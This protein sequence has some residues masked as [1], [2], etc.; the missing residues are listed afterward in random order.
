MVALL[1]CIMITS[2]KWCTGSNIFKNTAR[3]R[4]REKTWREN[5]KK[6]LSTYLIFL[7]KHNRRFLQARTTFKADVNKIFNTS[8]Q[9][10]LE[11]WKA[12]FCWRFSLFSFVSFVGNFVRLINRTLRSS[13]KCFD[14]TLSFGPLAN[15]EAPTARSLPHVARVWRS[16][17]PWTWGAKKTTPVM[18][19][20]SLVV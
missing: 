20:S 9:E 5:C 7:W 11:I 13:W 1:T 6:T 8:N 16:S 18:Q 2:K 12:F 4:C 3:F 17:L 10:N 15:T 19:A 14:F